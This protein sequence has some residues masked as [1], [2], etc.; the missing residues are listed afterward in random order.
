MSACAGHAFCDRQDSCRMLRS[1]TQKAMHML[2]HPQD[3]PDSTPDSGL[4]LRVCSRKRTIRCLL[5]S[6]WT[7]AYLSP[8]AHTPGIQ[9]LEKSY[10]HTEI[11]S[12]MISQAQARGTHPDILRYL[13]STPR[14]VEI[15]SLAALETAMLVQGNT[16]TKHS[17]FIA[18][19]AQ[20]VCVAKLI[21]LADPIVFSPVI[22]QCSRTAASI[23][24]SNML[25]RPI[26]ATWRL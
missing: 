15:F 26:V 5:T 22:L 9:T 6:S 16:T 25:L 14:Y 21:L 18:L 10:G 3:Q 12:S 7:A 17:C 1:Y 8:A 13:L 23:T 11:I 2:I 4:T 24:T 19:Q 20:C